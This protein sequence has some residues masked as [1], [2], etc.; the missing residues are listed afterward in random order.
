MWG[1]VQGHGSAYSEARGFLTLAVRT[2]QHGVQI[3][4]TGIAVEVLKLLERA[5]VI[6]RVTG[7]PVLGQLAL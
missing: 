1:L 6:A 5:H 4:S 7:G 3:R 2:A